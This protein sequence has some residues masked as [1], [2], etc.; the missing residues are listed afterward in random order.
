MPLSGR[1]LLLVAIVVAAAAC[2]GSA[3]ENAASVALR[4]PSAAAVSPPCGLR[5]AP[6]VRGELAFRIPSG[7]RA[8]RRR[9][10]GRLLLCTLYRRDGTRFAHL[11]SDPQERVLSVAFFRPSGCC[12]VRPMPSMP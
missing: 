10:A 11:T 3:A 2:A 7:G 1:R 5:L 9:L 4:A 6:P 12:G 8:A